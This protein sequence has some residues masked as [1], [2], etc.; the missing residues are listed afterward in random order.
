MSF[1]LHILRNQIATIQP[2]G[3]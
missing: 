3:L 2:I 1:P